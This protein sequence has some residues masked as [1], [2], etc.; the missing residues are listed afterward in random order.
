[1]SLAAEARLSF[2]RTLLQFSKSRSRT[3]NPGETKRNRASVWQWVLLSQ[4]VRNLRSS[5]CWPNVQIPSLAPW[6][7]DVWVPT[8]QAPCTGQGGI[9][10]NPSR[11]S[12]ENI[13]A[14]AVVV[15]SC[16]PNLSSR[17]LSKQRRWRDFSVSRTLKPSP[18]LLPGPWT[19]KRKPFWLS[20]LQATHPAL[21][22]P[23]TLRPLSRDTKLTETPCDSIATRAVHRYLCVA[24]FIFSKV[25]GTQ[26]EPS[27]VANKA[28]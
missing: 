13:R 20:N 16:G 22:D 8:Q 23:G 9:T 21:P 11:V 14:C 3:L 19:S 18:K 7:P 6:E 24:E 28:Q 25:V 17:P 12:A 1:M 15:G 4:F 26:R 27:D 2:L 5:S 10:R